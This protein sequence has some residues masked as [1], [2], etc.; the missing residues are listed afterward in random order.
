MLLGIVV[1]A[2]TFLSMLS[3][4]PVPPGGVR[5]RMRQAIPFVRHRLTG[6]SGPLVIPVAGVS[7]GMLRD[8]WNDAR[9]G[10]ARGHHGIDIMAPA[11]TPVLAAADGVVEKLFQSRLGGK[12]L[13]VRS[14]DLRWVYYY[15]HLAGYAPGVVEGRRVR[16]GEPIAY[17][18]DTGD[19]GAGNYHLHFG[20][21]RMGEDEHWWQGQDV[22]PYPLLAADGPAR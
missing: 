16:A 8:S 21:Q 19:A 20:L 17:V 1:I 2:A 4:S 18:G 22:N 12:T 10:G 14:P 5:D 15:A 11:G 7:R 13:Y 9:D 6:P 3:F